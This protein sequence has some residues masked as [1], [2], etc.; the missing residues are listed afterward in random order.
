MSFSILYSDVFLSEK[1]VE[2]YESGSLLDAIKT[3]YPLNYQDAVVSSKTDNGV[4]EIPA[5]MLP[6]FRPKNGEYIAFIKPK[7]RDIGRIAL[8]IALIYAGQTYAVPWLAGAGVNAGIAGALVTVGSTYLASA[9]IP[10]KQEP[11][12]KA[13]GSELSTSSISGS[14]NSISKGGTVP[15]LIGTHKFSPP[16]AIQPI[17]EY[18]NKTE[19]Y[20]TEVFCLGYGPLIIDY[21][22][23]KLG[24]TK[25]SSFSNV[26]IQVKD[27]YKNSSPISLVSGIVDAA[28]VSA[29]FSGSGDSAIR[30]TPTNCERIDVE[31][32]Y[33]SL[34][35]YNDKGN[36]VSTS[37]A[38]RIDYK[39]VGTS[40]WIGFNGS[41]IQDSVV[42]SDGTVELRLLDGETNGGGQKTRIQYVSQSYFTFPSGIPAHITA[43]NLFTVYGSTYNN[44]S[45]TAHSISGNRVYVGGYTVN[46]VSASEQSVSQYGRI[47]TNEST[48]IVY[49]PTATPINS[50]D[51]DAT[52]VATYRT[53]SL[54]NIKKSQY[55][56]RVT[57]ITAAPSSTSNT[58]NEFQWT[59]LKSTQLTDSNGQTIVPFSNEY[60]YIGLRIKATDQLNGSINNLSLT[61]TSVCYDYDETD[62][63]LTGN[64]AS[65]NPAWEYAKVLNG[66]AAKQR[67]DLDEIDIDAFIEWGA[68]C[69]EQV[70]GTNGIADSR[71]RINTVIDSATTEEDVLQKIASIGRAS[72]RW[73]DFK[74]SVIIDKP[75]I[76][77]SIFLNPANIMSFKW[78]KSFARRADA[79]NMSFY[80]KEIDY[81]KDEFLVKIDDSVA[82]NDLNYVEDLDA[83]GITDPDQVY[84]YGKFA[85]A[86]LKLRPET[87]TAT[88]GVNNLIFLRGDVIALTHDRVQGVTCFGQVLA[89]NGLVL[90][91]DNP[92]NISNADLPLYAT[93]SDPDAYEQAVA[94]YT[95]TDITDNF[96]TF[97]SLPTFNVVEA[98]YS[99][100]DTVSSLT[101]LYMVK[102][103]SSADDL[104]ATVQLVDY[105]S[106]TIYDAADSISNYESG[107]VDFKESEVVGPTPPTIEYIVTDESALRLNSDGSIQVRALIQLDANYVNTNRPE[108]TAVD[109]FYR[110]SETNSN[111]QRRTFN[112]GEELYIDNVSESLNYDF[113]VR[114][115]SKF[116]AASDFTLSNNVEIIGKTSPPP[117]VIAIDYNDGMITWSYP[118]PPLDLEGFQVRY[119]TGSTSIWES[120]VPLQNGV[121]T[122]SSF[123]VSDFISD[124]KSFFVKAIDTSGNYSETAAKVVVNLGDVDFSNIVVTIDKYVDGWPDTI[125]DGFINGSGFLQSTTYDF[126]GDDLALFYNVSDAA[127]FYNA[128]NREMTYTFD[129]T[130]YQI[131]S[132][133]RLSIGIKSS[134]D[135]A[136]IEWV[137]PSN[138]AFYSSDALSLFYDD[139]DS[140]FY[141]NTTDAV[142]DANE[143]T[144][145]SDDL[146]IFYG[147]DEALFYQQDVEANFSLFSG[148]IPSIKRIKYRFRVTVPE[149]TDPL[150][151][152]E[153]IRVVVDVKDLEDEVNNY[154]LID[155]S[156]RLPLS[157]DFRKIVNMQ[158]T[159]QDDN[160]TASYVKIVDKDELLG[161]LVE[162]YDSS[163]LKVTS[164][165]DALIRGY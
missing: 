66:T 7:D 80:N 163:G 103:I 78:E 69:N 139:D 95:V 97:A 71:F 79:Y 15:Y 36:K 58:R 145:Y 49:S 102:G 120:A 106:P 165:L 68:L 52:A 128:R 62:A 31:I 12:N 5:K 161:P 107:T 33:P 99:I 146:F 38:Y 6:Y 55:D 87:Y 86:Q 63:S 48:S 21:N 18:V 147:A 142:Y 130:P 2:S 101:R 24:D 150:S 50:T 77:P 157:L 113:K 100:G 160:G 134:I 73:V 129:F 112:I 105:A 85:H 118:N 27:N 74:E 32:G 76:Q 84:R 133:A 65:G 93:F 149:N 16:K 25:L 34:T 35:A 3:K 131:D 42:A 144:F 44:G 92:F 116:G 96:I 13:D 153:Y 135:S 152:L 61:A 19:A 137:Q 20:L 82:D 43:G 104:T 126:Y 148:V 83:T 90:T 22:N 4:F 158:L 30:T 11:A 75:D 46:N 1:T 121:I 17:T 59:Q 154:E 67:V 108:P 143:S 123:D 9:I 40:Q 64:L 26:E 111:F 94:T 45:F 110:V 88:L 164:V 28:I 117:D 57:R 10:Y 56:V 37:C 81:V 54:T 23:I 124:V 91:V 70:V 141:K 98:Y 47:L 125:S 138:D 51:T 14:G 8:T 39:E 53:H 119:A 89:R 162:T 60:C 122:T 114:Y 41:A 151:I 132:G 29:T 136:Y 159:L 156:G 140:V 155:G 109:V 127:M 72:R 115:L